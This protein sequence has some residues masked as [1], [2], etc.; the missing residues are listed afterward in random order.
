[1]AELQPALQ[2]K[3][4]LMLSTPFNGV[5]KLS[6]T[7]DKENLELEMTEKNTQEDYER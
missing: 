5:D 4:I 6:I 2:K 3:E 7:S 1:M